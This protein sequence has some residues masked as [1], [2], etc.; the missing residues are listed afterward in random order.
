MKE[1]KQLRNLME[2]IDTLSNQ[3]DEAEH[4]YQAAADDFKSRMRAVSGPAPEPKDW[5]QVDLKTF[6][7][8]GVDTADHPDYSDAF[9]SYGEWN[10]GTPLTDE[11][12]EQFQAENGEWVNERAY[13]QGVGAE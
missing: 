4:D 13:M 8:E 2:S 12:L 6:E 10:D 7:I 3:V 9:V 5:S 1:Q 11:E